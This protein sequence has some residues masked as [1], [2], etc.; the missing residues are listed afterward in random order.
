MVIAGFVYGLILIGVI[1]AIL[2]S[3]PPEADPAPVAAAEPTAT[4]VAT[5]TPTPRP[6]P[7]PTPTPAPEPTAT[8][9]PAPTATPTPDR[10]AE[11][12][13]A[14]YIKRMLEITE[15]VADAL[16]RFS[17]LNRNPQIGNDSWTIQVAAQL[18]VMRQAYQDFQEL[19]APPRFAD[20][21]ALWLDGLRLLDESTYLYTAGLDNL[22]VDLLEQSIEKV[23]EANEKIREATALVEA[24]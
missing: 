7:T 11:R 6:D 2:D 15:P 12:A 14:A 8:P 19:A 22:D 5:P 21:H 23:L 3:G 20:I 17:E 16:G 10:S 13:E 9:R 24:L 4:V 18:V 1:N